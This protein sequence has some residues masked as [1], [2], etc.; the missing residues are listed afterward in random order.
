MSDFPLLK[1]VPWYIR[2]LILIG[3][4]I[5]M[6]LSVDIAIENT[7]ELLHAKPEM[8]S[9]FTW[10]I[11]AC[12]I[13]G[14]V[15]LNAGGKKLLEYLAM[16]FIL[17]LTIIILGVIMRK[18]I[19]IIAG[20]LSGDE[21]SFMMIRK[22]FIIIM[23]LPYSMLVINSFSA[24]NLIARIIKTKGKFKTI[25]LHFALAIRVFQHTG[26]VIF[27]LLEIWAEEHPEKLLPRHRRDWG[28]K[29]YSKTNVFLW[30]VEAI[31]AWI[32]ACTIQTL[33][34]VLVMADEVEKINKLS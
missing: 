32:F 21:V 23:T 13:W 15:F 25:G 30:M 3:L 10:T 2:L 31:S 33:A 20:N 34:P 28:I 26:E 16:A 17:G 9:I 12:L 7:K 1:R 27:N 4:P 5:L 6:G 29:W 11:Y 19:P 18:L 8:A 24:Q 22:F 14:I